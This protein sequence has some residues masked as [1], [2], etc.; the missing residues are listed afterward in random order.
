MRRALVQLHK[1]IMELERSAYEREHGRV[2]PG[3]LLQLLMHNPWFGW[4]RPVSELVVQLDELLDSDE[5]RSEQEAQDL[6]REI[7]TLLRP[8]EAGE[9][10]STRYHNALQQDPDIILAHAETMNLLKQ[11]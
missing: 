11:P 1:A 2:A 10:F 9:E 7:R 5:P 3:E 6:L 4:F 8:A